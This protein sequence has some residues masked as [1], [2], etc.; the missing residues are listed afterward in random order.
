MESEKYLNQL[1]DNLVYIK[2]SYDEANELKKMEKDVYQ[3]KK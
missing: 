3:L 2:L 1:Q